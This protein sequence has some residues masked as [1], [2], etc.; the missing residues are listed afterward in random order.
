MTKKKEDTTHLTLLVLASVQNSPVD[1]SWI[2]FEIVRSFA[3]SVDE[4]QR[5]LIKNSSYYRRLD[6]I[7]QLHKIIFTFK[8][9][10]TARLPCPGYILKPLN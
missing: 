8:S 2:T 7:L 5:L 4:N 3:F 10:L 1:F 6:N 9:Y